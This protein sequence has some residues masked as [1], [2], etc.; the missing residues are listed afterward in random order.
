MANTM[1]T[2]DDVQSLHAFIMDRANEDWAAAQEHRAAT[3]EESAA[4]DEALARFNRISNSHKLAITCTAAYVLDLLNNE[5]D[6]EQTEL[7]WDHMTQAGEQWKDHPGF[8]PAWQ[9]AK[10]AQIRQMIAGG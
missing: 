10:M 2:A 9:N 3:A 5:G 7:A 6:D 1:P 8:L 4:E